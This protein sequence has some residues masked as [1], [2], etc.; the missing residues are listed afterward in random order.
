MGW[1]LTAM[2][3]VPA[4]RVQLEL[5]C[6]LPE[7]AS[8]R[9]AFFFGL[10]QAACRAVGLTARAIDPRH[11]RDRPA[12]PRPPD[13]APAPGTEKTP[14]EP[15]GRSTGAPR[16]ARTIVERPVCS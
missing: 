13:V 16:T 2:R 7:P 1:I 6:P 8:R 15:T 11:G 12:P 5:R 4:G 3:D 14:A 10:E 9:R